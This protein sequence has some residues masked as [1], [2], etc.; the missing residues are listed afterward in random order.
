MEVTVHAFIAL[1]VLVGLLR[2]IEIGISRRNQRKLERQGATKVP[3]PSFR[4]MVVFHI[5]ILAAAG[6]EVILLSRP[7]RSLLAITAGSMFL[8]AGGLRWW[9]IRVMAELWN[10]QVMDSADIGVVVEGPFRWIRH[11]NYAAV[12]L[13]LLA[14][15]LIHGAWITALLGSIIHW[16]ILRRRLK[17]EESVLMA[18]PAYIAAM[19]SKPRFIPSLF[20]T[21]LARTN[22]GSSSRERE[23]KI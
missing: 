4:W 17:L 14:L 12:F 16:S 22:G 10:I 6:A 15:P 9:V 2:L 5:G 1:L 20:R 3:D 13:E 7:F 19:G 23:R 8:L 21:H 18:K 11:P